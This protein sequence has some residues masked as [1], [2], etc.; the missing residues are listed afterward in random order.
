MNWI[1]KR[2]RL[3]STKPKLPTGE[4]QSATEDQE[5]IQI[6]NVFETD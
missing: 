2:F 3:E 5:V 6:E 1:K 4:Q